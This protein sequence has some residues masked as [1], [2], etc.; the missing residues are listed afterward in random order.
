MAVFSGIMGKFLRE[1][2]RMEPKMGLEYG[3]LPKEISMKEIGCS[4]DNMERESIN[5]N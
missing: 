2:G 3:N 1:S 5:I 4:I